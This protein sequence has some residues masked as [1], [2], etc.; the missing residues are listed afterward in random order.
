MVPFAR[1]AL[2]TEEAVLDELA[3]PTPLRRSPEKD[4]D[5]S[6]LCKE[7]LSLGKLSTLVEECVAMALGAAA[8]EVSET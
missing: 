7:L 2:K 5:S 3:E 1:L 4:S 6:E 8:V